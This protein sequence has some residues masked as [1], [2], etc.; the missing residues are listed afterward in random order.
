MDSAVL[1]LGWV[2]E[3]WMIVADSHP[4]RKKAFRGITVIVAR[5]GNIFLGNSRQVDDG[6]GD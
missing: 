6:V 3:W 2:C 1:A 4:R 5:V